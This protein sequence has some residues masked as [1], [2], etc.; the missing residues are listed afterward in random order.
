MKLQWF[1]P[2]KDGVYSAS[3]CPPG[4][5]GGRYAIQPVSDTTPVCELT[6]RNS[7][8]EHPPTVLGVFNSPALAQAAAQSDLD[9]SI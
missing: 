9:N 3:A 2:N 7:Y 4:I 6:Y 1:G 8:T 5:A